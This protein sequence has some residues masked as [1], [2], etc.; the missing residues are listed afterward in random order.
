MSAAFWN[1]ILADHAASQVRAT[2]AVAPDHLTY[3]DW[4]MD[5]DYGAPAWPLVWSATHKNF[6][7]SYE[8]PEDG[9]VGSHPCFT[10]A[11]QRD[12]IEQ[13]DCW[14]LDEGADA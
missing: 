7:A 9:W 10:A 8:G 11:T 12:L 2:K 13:I 4:R 1:G 14:Y 5:V 3:R 6:D